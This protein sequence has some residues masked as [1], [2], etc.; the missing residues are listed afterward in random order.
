MIS[1]TSFITRTHGAG[2]T[3][4]AGALLACC[5]RPGDVILLEGDLGAGKTQFSQGFASGLGVSENVISPTFNIVISYV[6]GRFPIHHFDLY[7]LDSADQ[8]EDI[9]L[10]E[11]LESDGACLVEWAEKFPEAFDEYLK[12]TIEKASDDERVLRASACGRRADELSGQWKAAFGGDSGTAYGAEGAM[13]APCDEKSIGGTSCQREGLHAEDPN[14]NAAATKRGNASL[15]EDDGYV[16]AFDTSNEVVAIAIGKLACESKAIEALACREVRAHRASNTRLVPCIDELMGEVGLNRRSISCV[17]VGRGP[18]SFTGVRIAM[19]TAKGIAQALGVPLVGVSTLDAVALGVQAGGVRGDL[20][21]VADAMRKEVYPARF[22]LDESGAHRLGA[23]RVVKADAFALELEDAQA[24]AEALLITG[25]GLVKYRGQFEPFGTVLDETAWDVTG[26]GLLL[27]LQQAWRR[28]EVDPLDAIRHDPAFALPV[29]T[30]LSDA[31]EN[32]RIRLARDDE[33][34]LAAGVQDVAPDGGKG[35][36]TMHATA[37]LSTPAGVSGIAYRPL[38]A[39]H[40]AAVAA[41]EDEVMGGDA[42]NERLV[43]EELGHRDRSWWAAFDGDALVGYAGGLVVDGDLQVLKVAVDPS[44]RRRG[45]ARELLARVADDARSLGAKTCS[46]EVRVSNEGAQR[47]YHALGLADVGTRPRYYSDREDALIMAG[48][49]PVEAHG[50]AGMELKHLEGAA[51]SSEKRPLILAIESSCDETAAAVVNGEGRLLS[52][53]VASQIGFHAR[54][55]GVVPEI[56]SRKHIEAICGVCAEALDSAA[57]SSGKAAGTVRWRDL[58]AVAV[59]YAPGLLGALVV[60]VAFAKGAAWALDVP[61]IGVNHL[62]GHL[63]ANKVGA[64]DFEPPAVVSLVSGGNTMLVHMKGWGDYV[65]LGATIDDAVGEAFDKVSKALGLG[66]PGGPVISKWAAEGDPAAI[67]FPRAMLHSHDLRFSL[68]G[69]KTAVV[70]YINKERQAGREL[71]IADIAASFQQAVVD[72]QVAK[73]E[74]ALVQTGARTFCLGGGVA[75]NPELR[76]AYERMC[77]KRGVRLV[78]P[79]LS[80]CGDN[81]GMIALVALDRYAQRKFFPLDADALAHASLDD[82]Y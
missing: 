40:A 4:R 79:P 20:L 67:D 41:L 32:E 13:P 10:R 39:A 76:R 17:C 65:T 3:R 9:G 71:N 29:Y 49:L 31:E 73:A 34:N 61:F 6:T 43:S 11:Y 5:A 58:D 57:A 69:L 81:A 16:L 23:D 38:D 56:A 42:W 53:V 7:R 47:F 24:D 8:L 68:S 37:P 62:E 51:R 28:G 21:V 50:V 33:R 80:S 48:P 36:R 44:M 35:R 19:A 1:E 60:G 15:A 14:S 55:G 25:D 26:N 54:F 77:A 27:T 70:N 30:R 63:Y 2:Q 78:M 18:G 82:P 74:T 52:D 66:Y 46:L 59:T 72:V 12:V 75:A 45:V 22:S 64:D